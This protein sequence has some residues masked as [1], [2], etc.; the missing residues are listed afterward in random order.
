[1]YKL[2]LSFL[3]SFNFL[4]A[5]NV[6][7]IFL[8]NGNEIPLLTFDKPN[9]IEELLNQELVKGQIF[10]FGKFSFSL[11]FLKKILLVLASLCEFSKLKAPPAVAVAKNPCPTAIN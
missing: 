3:L 2:I 9:D 7:S 5:Q 11:L 6:K 10:N 8:D 4:T 1:M